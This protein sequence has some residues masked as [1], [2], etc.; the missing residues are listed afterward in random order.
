MKSIS[1]Q[2]RVDDQ[3]RVV[4]ELPREMAGREVQMIVVFEPA[5]AAPASEAWPPDFFERVAGSIPDF[6]DIESEGDFEVRKPLT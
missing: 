5:P 2:A 4:V 1:V 3:A 6:P